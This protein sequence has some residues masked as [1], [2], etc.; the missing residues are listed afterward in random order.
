MKEI[1]YIENSVAD[2]MIA[3]YI[4]S[5]MFSLKDIALYLIIMFTLG[6]FFQFHS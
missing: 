1:K 6:M 2:F 4:F 3:T 5:C